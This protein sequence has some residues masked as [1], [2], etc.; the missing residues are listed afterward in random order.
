[1]TEDQAALL[2]EKTRDAYSA[3]LYGASWVACA[4]LLARRGLNDAEIEAVLRSKWMRWAA[5]SSFHHKPTSEDL[6]RFMDDP[7]NEC[8]RE[9]IKRLVAGTL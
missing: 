4:K 6:A 3:S 2:A 7:R 8:T 9:N 1:M 5:D